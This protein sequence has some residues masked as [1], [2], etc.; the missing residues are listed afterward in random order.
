MIVD[1]LNTSNVLLYALANYDNAQCISLNEFKSDIK[2]FGKLNR[3]LGRVANTDINLNLVMNGFI[4]LHNLFGN[5]TPRLM[6]HYVNKR[7]WC[8]MLSFLE[9][10]NITPHYIPEVNELPVYDAELLTKLI[11]TI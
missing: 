10:L 11:S 6:F 1:K 3:Q 4:I 8:A 2:L 5:A 7:N 9:Y